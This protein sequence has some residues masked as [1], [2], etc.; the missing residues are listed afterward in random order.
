M[1]AERF[2]ATQ[3]LWGAYQDGQLEP[4]KEAWLDLEPNF[5]EEIQ[6]ILFFCNE[7][8]APGVNP[9]LNLLHLHL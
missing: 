7:P 9:H 4:F 8:G 3:R 1:T 5:D 6:Y 2:G